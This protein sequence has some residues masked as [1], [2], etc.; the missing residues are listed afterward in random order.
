MP[1]RRPRKSVAIEHSDG[2]AILR[3]DIQF[4]FLSHIFADHTKA[5]TDPQSNAKLSFRDSYVNALLRSPK[6]KLVLKE[7]LADA[8]FATD[9]AMLALL[10]NVGRISTTMSFF[11]EM[12]TAQRTYHPIPCLQRTNGNLLD[13]PR[14]KHILKTSVL[15]GE[16]KN[17]LATPAQVLARAKA[18][19]IPPTTLPSLIFIF[20]NHSV[21]IGHNHFSDFEFLDLFLPGDTSSESRAR[22]FLWL[23]YHYLEGASADTDDDYDG[24]G[25]STANPFSGPGK[26]PRLATLT[27][28]EVALENVDPEEETVLAKRLISQRESIVQDNLRKESA[29]ESKA[30]GSPA[31]DSSPVK[32]QNKRGRPSTKAKPST[33]IR[34]K[35][36]ALED[37]EEEAE[38]IYLKPF[39]ME[40]DDDDDDF[41]L[42]SPGA[43]TPLRP[44]YRQ[45]RHATSP[46]PTR[47][48]PFSPLEPHS[49]RYSPY[50]P[51]PAR[52]RASQLRARGVQRTMLQQA[53]HAIMNTDPLADSEDEDYDEHARRDHTRRLE[54][55]SRIRRKAPTPEPEGF[56][57]IPLYP[58]QWHDD[59]NDQ[60]FF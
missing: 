60:Y 35:A 41:S 31:G 5:F 21:Q 24:D 4:D 44:V 15:E 14:I 18:G 32:T 36:Q 56:L 33:P 53:W 10:T 47:S 11:A 42:I 7:K 50:K 17:L 16:S 55:I 9:F 13:A 59:A 3:A 28:E 26:T 19:Q 46:L 54:V 20:A 30:K 43:S 40:V 34:Q 57:P 51:N 6:T 25:L 58:H 38:K 45:E 1:A 52:S 23:C 29:K 12:R 37:H 2:E 49:R 22:A 39:K 8:T 48:V 27:P